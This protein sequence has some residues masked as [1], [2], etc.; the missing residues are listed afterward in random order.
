MLN[1]PT[2]QEVIEALICLR[3]RV[4]S[5]NTE[6]DMPLKERW[7]VPDCLAYAVNILEHGEDDKICFTKEELEKHDKKVAQE[8]EMLVL[9]A[10]GVLQNRG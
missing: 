5:E 7:Y 4:I 10:I 3:D 6:M 9:K 8:K 2:K 1:N